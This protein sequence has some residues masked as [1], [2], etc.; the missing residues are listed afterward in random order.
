LALYSTPTMKAL[1]F[2]CL[3][4]AAATPPVSSK[5]LMGFVDKVVAL[6]AEAQEE[7]EPISP[8]IV[9]GSDVTTGEYSF[10]VQGEGCGGSLVAPDVVLTAAHCE[11]AFTGSTVIVGNYRWG[12]VTEG[13]EE[14]DIVSSMYI[15]PDFVYSWTTLKNDLM[16]FKIEPSTLPPIDLNSDNSIPV[17]GQDLTVIGFGAVYEGGDI[18]DTLQKTT[19]QAMSYEEC[20]T[21]TLLANYEIDETSMLCASVDDASSDS[22]QGDSGGPLFDEGTRTLM[23][24][25]S[26]GLGCARPNSPGVYARVSG[27]IDWIRQTVCDITD[28][29]PSICEG[30]PPS[31][32]PPVPPPS[33]SPI[34]DMFVPQDDLNQGGG[35]DDVGD[36]LGA[37]DSMTQVDDGTDGQ[38]GW[39]FDDDFWDFLR[40]GGGR[41]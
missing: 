19:L 14:L 32:P 17:D 15:H 38:G 29:S 22:C 7:E 18:Y 2:A 28:T 33:S 13:A 23:G 36:D 25:V 10:F 21:D 9:G 11:T 1:A 24:V 40:E 8:M 35:T 6:I 16:L 5:G 27:N 3:F 34:D 30:L 37:D 4:A 41:K 26:W 12:E 39:W 31:S 20:S